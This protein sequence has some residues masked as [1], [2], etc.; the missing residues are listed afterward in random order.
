MTDESDWREQIEHER[1]SKDEYF[2]N[3][4]RSPIP[5]ELRDELEGLSY[6]SPDPDLRYELTLHEHDQKETRT[7]AT[8]ADGEQEYVVWG[9]F[10]FEVDGE[11]CTLQAYRSDPD[12]DRLWLP[13]RDETNGEDT[14]GAGRY[15]D[16]EAEH[17]LDDDSW[18]VDFNEAYSP[19]CAYS[20]RYECPLI[21]M[22]N[23]LDVRIEAGE[24]HPPRGLEAL[25]D[26][27]DH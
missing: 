8:T 15:I 10:R 19:L 2:R 3:H 14:Y 27:P 16:L 26:N 17:R 5:R 24:R 21:P 18:L 13:F 25:P 20:P 22:E 23:W 11:E 6:Y 7:V 1:Q 12:E 4:P 9:E